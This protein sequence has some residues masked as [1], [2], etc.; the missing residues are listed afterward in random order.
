LRTIEAS[1]ITENIAS[2]CQEANFRL[3][4][5]VR[6][7][8]EK[9]LQ[10]EESPVGK[11][12]L[13]QILDNARLAE[14]RSLPICQD[15]GVALVFLDLG[16]DLRITGGD[17]NEAVQAGVRLGYKEGY[18]RK[19]MVT[20]PFSERINTQDNT[21]AI[22]HINIVPGDKLKITVMPKGAGSENMSRLFML[23]PSSGR[24]GIIDAVVKAVEEAGSNACPPVTLGIGIGG[25]AEK[26]MEMSKTALLRKVGESSPDPETKQLEKDI[27]AEINKL[28]IGPQGFGGRITALA[29]NIETFPAHIGSMPLGVNIQCHALRRKQAV[30]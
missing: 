6:E 26:A 8:L 10:S 17:L 14:E 30:I 9:A 25:N 22:V 24:Q 27:L 7:A 29:V 28:G 20:K 19:S 4:E 2:L 11:D 18:L 23:T 5:D 12:V 13:R 16:Q 1:Q 3:P 21:P 15:C